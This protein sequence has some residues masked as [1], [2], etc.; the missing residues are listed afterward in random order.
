MSDYGDAAKKIHI[1]LKGKISIISK[2]KIKTREDLSILYTP[3]V[4]EP[5][6]EIARDKSLTNLYTSR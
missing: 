3:G 1:A 5:C 6:R 2:K 4:A